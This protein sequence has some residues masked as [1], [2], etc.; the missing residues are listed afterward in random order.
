MPEL[1]AVLAISAATGLRLA[2][3]L[4]LIGLFAEERLWSTVPILA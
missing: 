2:L 3:P 4:L 1:L